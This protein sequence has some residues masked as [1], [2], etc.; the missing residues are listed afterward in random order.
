MQKRLYTALA[1]MV[2]FAMVLSAC[3]AQPTQPPAPT[4]VPPTA[5]PPTPRPPTAVP[6]TAAPLPVIEVHSLEDAA[7]GVRRAGGTITLPAFAG[8]LSVRSAAPR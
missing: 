4:P 8:P 5:V 2:M 3:G 1:F 7:A 6:P